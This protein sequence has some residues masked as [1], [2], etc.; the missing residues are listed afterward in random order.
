MIITRAPYRISLAGGSADY[1]SF[2]SRH[3]ALLVGFTINRYV[4]I[5][6]KKNEDVFGPKHRIAYSNIELVDSI[7]AIQNPGVR[8]PLQYFGIE[9]GLSIHIVSDLPKQAGI[10]SSSALCVALCKAIDVYKNGK[11]TL[12]KKELAKIAIHIERDMLG[13]SGGWQDQVWSSYG[14]PSSIEIEKDGNIKVRPLSVSEEFLDSLRERMVLSHIGN[15]RLSFELASKHDNES[16]VAI[17]Q[18]IKRLAELTLQAFEAEDVREI[19]NLL[20]KGWLLK[21][22]ITDG[23]SNENIDYKYELARNAGALGGKLLG[24]GGT[25]FMLFILDEGV[26]KEQF[27]DTVK[28]DPLNFDYSY[29]GAEVFLK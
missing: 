20:H 13:E 15:G 29:G 28:L 27:I 6:L 24:T 25:G 2:F 19:G 3:G 4:Y 16:S 1:P 14:S 12:S 26:N 17:K 9:D 23:I 21:R 7:D 10:G 5:A 22:S 18:Q 8:G 11:E